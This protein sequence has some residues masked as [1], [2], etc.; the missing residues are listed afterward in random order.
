MTQPLLILITGANQGI[1]YHTT[2]HLAS[3]GKYHILMGA[4]SLAKAE[5]AAKTLSETKSI[6]SNLLEPI[7]ID[8]CSDDSITAAAEKVKSKYGHLDILINNAGIAAVPKSKGTA[9][10]RE[11]FQEIYN[12]NVSG[13]AVVTDTF[14]PLIK[15]SKAPKP[16]RRIVF[17]ST[18]LASMTNHVNGRASSIYVPYSASKAAENVLALD[19]ILALKGENITIV[20][21]TPGFCGTNLNGFTG[22]RDPEDG[23][24]EIVYAATE[25]EHGTF[26]KS[27][28]V[29]PW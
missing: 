19:Y 26:M 2:Q 12:T 10:T 23:A 15:A 25:Q 7:E 27:G 14:I 8:L 22:T 17:V 29:V 13:T 16:G 24:T 11:T 20:F 3:T 1:G 4:R 6:P 5:E 28:N 21:T 18:E 9:T